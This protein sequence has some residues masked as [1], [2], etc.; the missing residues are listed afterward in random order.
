LCINAFRVWSM[1]QNWEKQLSP[2]RFDAHCRHIGHLAVWIRPHASI[3]TSDE[4]KLQGFFNYLSNQ[5]AAKKYSPEPRPY[6]AHDR[7]AAH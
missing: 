6:A 2:G 4:G 7:Q 3:D 1:V 5:V